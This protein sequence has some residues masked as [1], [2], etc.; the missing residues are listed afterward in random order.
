MVAVLNL[1][2]PTLVPLARVASTVAVF[3]GNGNTSNWDV[4]TDPR[5]GTWA[6]TREPA[7]GH[8]PENRH[9]GTDPRTGVGTDPRTSMWAP[10]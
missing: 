9:V 3:D 4:G 10:T 8:R 7:C 2:V 1:V 6:P 5:T